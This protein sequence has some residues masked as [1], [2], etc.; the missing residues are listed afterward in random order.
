M[1]EHSNTQAQKVSYISTQQPSSL[2]FANQYDPVEP[3][4]N[5]CNAFEEK[6]SEGFPLKDFDFQNKVKDKYETKVGKEDK[7]L[8]VV[9]S[10]WTP[11][12]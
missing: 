3:K 5:C 6:S 1:E 7:E 11:T 10:L 8:P 4:L 2:C 12:S 9:L